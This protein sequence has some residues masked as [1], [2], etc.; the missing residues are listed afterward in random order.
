MFLEDDRSRV[1]L[2][3]LMTASA[4]MLPILAIVGAVLLFGGVL[5]P[6]S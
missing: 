6:G 3:H 4:V 1:R 2:M 5:N